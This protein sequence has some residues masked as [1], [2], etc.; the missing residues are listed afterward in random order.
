M[1]AVIRNAYTDAIIATLDLDDKGSQRFKKDWQVPAD[2]SGEGF[3]ISIVTSVYTDSG[4]TTKSE[5]YGDEE[6][7]YL[8]SEQAASLRG[9][10]VGQGLGRGTGPDAYTIRRIVSEE[11]AKI[12]IP[13]AKDI[14]IPTPKEY[15]MRWDDVLG[16]VKQA[17]VDIIKAIPAPSDLAPL[18][19]KLT[20]LEQA[21]KDKEVTPVTDLEPVINAL[22]VLSDALEATAKDTAER[23]EKFAKS[24]PKALKEAIDGAEFVTS[25]ITVAS[26]GKRSQEIATSIA[27]RENAPEEE[28]EEEEEKRQPID[29]TKLAQ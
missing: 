3:Y 24:L 22:D 4:Y 5:N 29:I 19:D 7:T 26:K 25:A 18:S 1:R 11:I 13:E 21:I 15:E 10:V 6:N 27:E 28:E 9:G 2:P 23:T 8:V 20:A 14:V 17:T 16:A 12:K